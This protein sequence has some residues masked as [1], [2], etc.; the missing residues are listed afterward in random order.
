MLAPDA[1]LPLSA[2]PAAADARALRQAARR[3]YELQ[4]TGSDLPCAT[5]AEL[6]IERTAVVLARNTASGRVIHACRY[7]QGKSS[8]LT[9]YAQQ[10]LTHVMAEWERIESLLAGDGG[11]WAVLLQHLERVAYYWLGPHGREEWARWEAREAAAQTCADLWHWLKCK[12]F[13]FDVP[14]DHWSERVLRN[15]LTD[16]VRYRNRDARHVVDSLDRPC[17]EDGDPHGELLPTDD[18]GVW[19]ELE[20]RREVVRKA[21][22]RLEQRQARILHLWYLEGWSVDEIA[23]ETLLQVDHI[24]V[25]KHRGLKKLREYCVHA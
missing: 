14:F 9:T 2:P 19:L 17:V 18:M 16:S 10:V 13:P 23:A 6:W 15:R 24:Y 21:W 4:S 11:C 5:D 3:A 22:R 1:G 25:L 8:S 12:P 7:D 20:S